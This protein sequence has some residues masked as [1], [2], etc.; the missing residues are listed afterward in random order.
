MPNTLQRGGVGT[1]AV[2]DLWRL[3]RALRMAGRKYDSLTGPGGLGTVATQQ[4]ERPETWEDF[5]RTIGTIGGPQRPT[6]ITPTGHGIEAIAFQLRWPNRAP[7][8]FKM[9]P[10][11]VGDAYGGP[12]DVIRAIQQGMPPRTLL[13]VVKAGTRTSTP[14]SPID[15]VEQVEG[16]PLTRMPAARRLDDVIRKL[17]EQEHPRWAYDDV[18]RGNFANW[19]GRDWVLDLGSVVRK[20]SKDFRMVPLSAPTDEILEALGRQA[21]QH[22]FPWRA[23]ERPQNDPIQ[24]VAQALET[25]SRRTAPGSEQL[26]LFTMSPTVRVRPRPNRPEFAQPPTAQPSS[27]TWPFQVAPTIPSASEVEQARQL[28]DWGLARRAVSGRTPIIPDEKLQKLAGIVRDS[29]VEEFL[30]RTQGSTAQAF[31][32]LNAARNRALF[33]PPPPRTP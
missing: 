22:A 21:R 7:T 28:V 11:G 13:P 8:I 33:P 14:R 15:W 32:D 6:A 16:V 9:W 5:R 4:L 29:A 19:G 10:R 27:P 2:I 1:P 23:V 3:L 31:L 20:Y 12:G 30:R 25:F 26:P 17:T 24:P 18:H